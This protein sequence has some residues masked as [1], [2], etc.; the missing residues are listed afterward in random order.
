MERPRVFRDPVH[1]L[2]SFPG[3]VA[4]ILDT[5]AFQRLRRIRQDGFASLVY[6]GAEHSR[7]G[8]ALGAY[9]IAQRVTTRL[10][11]DPAL[12]RDVHLAALVHD[13]G[14]GPFSHAWEVAFGGTSHE[15]WGA[16]ILAEDPEVRSLLGDIHPDLPDA[17]ARFFAGTYRPRFA[18]KLISSE[19]DVDRMDYLLRDAHY[20]GVGYSAYDLEWILHALRVEAVAGGDDPEDLVIDWRRGRYA[21]EQYL[22]GR[23]YMYAQVYYHKT[24]RAAEL[25]FTRAMERFA[26]LA[27]DGLEPGGLPAAAALA[28]GEAVGVADYLGLD[29]AR[30]WCAM[31]DW[32]RAAADEIL[33]DL[34]GRLTARRLFKAIEV[35]GHVPLERLA[36]AAES[37]LGERAP[38]YWVVDRAEPSVGRGDLHVVGHP[39]HG[40]VLLAKLADEL[41]IA[42]EALTVR[43]LCARELVPAFQAVLCG[44]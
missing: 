10:G 4:R 31:D 36:M 17:Q 21:V 27:A 9:H 39:R 15:A 5:R 2:I 34:C 44:P 43:V 42:R 28:R 20:T 12:A 41:P 25:M 6:P 8:H 30:V 14:H 22:F 38:Y 29:D 33:R 32:G 35:A 13:I 23:F 3:D 1:G 19:L 37:V 26:E 40:T 24:V 16:R 7:F 18:R 11:V